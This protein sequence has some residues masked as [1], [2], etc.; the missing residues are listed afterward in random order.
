MQTLNQQSTTNYKRDSTSYESE[1]VIFFNAENDMSTTTQT[2]QT[3]MATTMVKQHTQPEHT[4][5]KLPTSDTSPRN[6]EKQ[7][8]QDIDIAQSTSVTVSKRSTPIEIS[9]AQQEI[10]VSPQTSAWSRGQPHVALPVTSR[11]AVPSPRNIH[12]DAAW[13]PGRPPSS[14]PAEAEPEE[15]KARFEIDQG[16]ATLAALKAWRTPAQPV[17]DQ[18]VADA[19]A[20]MMT[21]I[22]RPPTTQVLLTS[23]L[24]L[25]HN[26]LP[27]PH[28]PRSIDTGL[29]QDPEA[30]VRDLYGE[31]ALTTVRTATR[32]YTNAEANKRGAL[33]EQPR[34]RQVRGCTMDRIQEVRSSPAPP[35]SEPAV[36]LIADRLADHPLDLNTLEACSSGPSPAGPAL[37]GASSAGPARG[38]A[39]VKWRFFCEFFRLFE[40][41]QNL[42]YFGAVFGSKFP[43]FQI[44]NFGIGSKLCNLVFFRSEVDAELPLALRKINFKR[45]LLRCS[46]RDML[47]CLA[48]D[49]LT[50]KND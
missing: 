27:P 15:A 40:L 8:L 16:A 12:G 24:P 2:F 10:K 31:P 42:Q 34:S 18:V 3:S 14:G 6:Q 50:A 17:L 32:Y 47:R 39:S 33:T 5:M 35:I 20:E 49:L 36:I 22:N 46:R 30:E 11:H 45:V 38:S 13:P 9:A 43:N 29:L 19:Y 41:F 25:S 28:I 23:T 44:F 21:M 37:G 1:K 48:R 4:Q 7:K 26:R